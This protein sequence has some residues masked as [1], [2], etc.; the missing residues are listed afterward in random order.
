MTDV[1][2]ASVNNSFSIAERTGHSH[3]HFEHFVSALTLTDPRVCRWC[4]CTEPRSR[5]SLIQD[6]QLTFP[7]QQQPH[8]V[9][10]SLNPRREQW[11]LIKQPRCA[12]MSPRHNKG[13]FLQHDKIFTNQLSFPLKQLK[14][15]ATPRS[16]MLYITSLLFPLSEVKPTLW[17]TNKL[18]IWAGLWLQRLTRLNR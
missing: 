5:L 12:N 9:S 10:T 6:A 3:S 15:W 14:G 11:R 16:I 1:L 4:T 2:W 18:W 7:Q 17:F 13:A 8:N